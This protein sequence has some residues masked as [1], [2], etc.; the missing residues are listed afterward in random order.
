MRANLDCAASGLAGDKPEDFVENGGTELFSLLL[1]LSGELA[2]GRRKIDAG[3]CVFHLATKRLRGLGRRLESL[4]S[5]SE[6]DGEE[7]GDALGDV[8]E[9]DMVEE[10]GI[11]G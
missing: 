8:G 9:D 5:M 10:E 7:M 6:I 1:W 4:L 3:W 11:V 2:E